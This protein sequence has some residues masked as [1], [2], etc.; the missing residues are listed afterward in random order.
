M[1]P[2]QQAQTQASSKVP[3]QDVCDAERPR[4]KQSYCR[5][6]GGDGETGRRDGRGNLSLDMWY[7]S[8]PHARHDAI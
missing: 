5:R 6:A 3:Q 2:Q 4:T 1:T 8:P 7:G